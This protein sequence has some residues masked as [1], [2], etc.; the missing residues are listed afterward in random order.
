MNDI[1]VNELRRSADAIAGISPEQIRAAADVMIRSLRGGGQV[2]FMGN[3]G[4]Q[5]MRNT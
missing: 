1:I 2:I 5:Q 3:G 4:L